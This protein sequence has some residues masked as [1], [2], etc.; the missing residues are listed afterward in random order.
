MG[1]SGH[2]LLP[3]KPRGGDGMKFAYAGP[4]YM[5]CAKKYPE[6]TEVDHP[7]LIS[8]LTSDYPD[9]WALSLSSP[10]LRRLLPLCPIDARVMAW[11]KPFAVYKPNVGVA[12]AWEPVIVRGGRKRTRGQRTVKDWISANITLRKG[13]AGTKPENFALWLYEVFNART[14]DSL[15]DLYPGTGIMGKCWE[16]FI[17]ERP[18]PEEVKA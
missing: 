10:S 4:P 11:V 5:G 13:L 12:Y 18:A 6:K 15:D 2:H 9:G 16:R 17:A 3:K 14:G 7:E 1:A 8:R